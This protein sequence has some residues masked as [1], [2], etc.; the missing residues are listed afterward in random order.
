M[1]LHV[2]EMILSVSNINMGP[3]CIAGLFE[4]LNVNSCT[5]CVRTYRI[6]AACGIYC[7]YVMHC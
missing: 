3:I 2:S 6:A 5:D 1:D 7:V 4:F